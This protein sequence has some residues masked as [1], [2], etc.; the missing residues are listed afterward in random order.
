MDMAKIIAE[1][2]ISPDEAMNYVKSGMR[3]FVGSGS[4]EPQTLVSQL[5]HNSNK[6]SDIEIV[7]LLTLGIAN[8]VEQSYKYNFRHNAFFIGPNVRKAVSEG[9]ADYTP[10]FLSEIPALFRTGQRKI[11]VAL[12][13]LSPPDRHGYCSMGMNVDIQ[14]AAM[15]SARVVLAE[16][17]PLVPRTF[18]AGNI[19]INEITAYIESNTP[20]L[21]LAEPEIDQVS[22]QIG[23]FVS[24]LIDHKSCLQM[25][26]GAIPSAVLRYLGDKRDLGI[27]TEMFTDGILP[28]VENGN[29]TNKYKTHHAGKIVTSFVMGTGRLYDFVNDN[30][31]VVFYPSDY[32]NDPRI[33]SQNDQVVAINSA[34]QVDLTGQVCADSIGFNFY[35]GIG[36]QVDFIR[37]AAMSKG[38]KPIIA[39]PSTAKKG[40]IS[41]IVPRLDEGAGVVTS[42]G[43]VHYVV[44]EYGVAY[45][46]GK[47]IRERALALINIAHPD[48]RDEL[49]DFVKTKHYVYDD[50]KV[51]NNAV[52]RYPLE[53]ESTIDFKGVELAVRPLKPTDEKALQDFFYSHEPETVYLRHNVTKKVMSHTEAAMRCSVDYDRSMALGAFYV[54]DQAEDIVSVAR[55]NVNP[56]NNLAE[57]GVV[58]HEKYRRRGIATYLI[59][60]LSEYARSRGIAG[61]YMEINSNNMP[62]VELEKKQN[63]NIRLN[64]DAG[65]YQVEEFFGG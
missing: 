44:T 61:V 53:M 63:A 22:E 50:E 14:L 15:Q 65:C 43:D 60:K 47:T 9:R 17:N 3:V 36:G 45:L 26:I 40:T 6:F 31:G 5:C 1:K 27:H 42:R 33:I 46:H 48:Y 41:R 64:R 57:V 10:I 32:V 49:L 7:H 24:R 20:L 19:H 34:L 21:E 2:K 16:L 51:W 12:L 13:Q 39:L 29:I 8:Y 54:H 28:L 55:Y 25:G 4:S 30:P 62:M 23:A 11:D 35:S 56:M 38:G 59:K 52:N 58:V 18:G 37:G